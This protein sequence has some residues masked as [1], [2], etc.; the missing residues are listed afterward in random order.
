MKIKL[1]SFHLWIRII[2]IASL[3]IP[4]VV[5]R[6]RTGRLP[7]GQTVF[8]SLLAASTVLILLPVA[9]EDI[10]TSL[11]FALLVL[12]DSGCCA[13]IGFPCAVCVL[14]CLLLILV[15]QIYRL[16][17]RHSVLRSLFKPQAV[18]YSLE[19]HQRLILS[20]CTGLLAL[21]AV[22]LP[23]HPVAVC[24]LSALLLLL[25]V[26]LYYRALTGR[27][28]LLSRRREKIV[29]RMIS[30]IEDSSRQ[31]LSGDDREEIEK[32]KNIF[33]K[34]T[35]IMVSHR[36]FLDPDYSIQDLADTTYINK[37]YVSKTINNISGKNFRQFVNCY[38]VQYAMELLEE[39][40]R[41]SVIEL[42]E[43]S[44]FHSS[45][46]FTMAF[47]LNMGETPGEYTLK[48]RA[49]L[50]S[51]LSTRQERGLQRGSQSCG[52]GG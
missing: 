21:L 20:L 46:T 32:E 25:Y 27:C 13:L 14:V 31:A 52:Q 16:S 50:V 42:A 47:K 18:W 7:G 51:P 1:C 36:P 11:I 22:A 2:S 5:S 49:G 24:L 41:L 10:R 43:K 19:S 33:E 30:N 9:D 29:K 3:L 28:L 12:I 15:H 37:T 44:G 34:I 40:P 4:I 45:V 38:R 26:L 8:A 17:A 39:N 23:G 48:L 35:N 6:I